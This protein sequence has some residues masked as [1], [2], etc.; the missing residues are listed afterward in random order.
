[1]PIGHLYV[2]F[3]KKWLSVLLLLFF[4][5]Y[6]VVCFLGV[7]SKA[8]LYVLR[9]DPLSVMWSAGTSSHSE[10][11]RHFVDDFLCCAGAFVSAWVRLVCFCCCLSC[12]GRPGDCCRVGLRL[13]P[14]LGALWFQVL[15]L[16]LTSILS[17]CAWHGGMLWSRVL[18]VA[19]QFS[20]DHLVKWLSLVH[21]ILLPFS[22]FPL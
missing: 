4:F 9:V 5:F 15:L 12:L 6:W 19:V 22:A 18:H 11:C 1:M 7:E 21:Y 17:V 14:L 20:Q 2:V 16:G 13:F 10:G 3:G 8:L